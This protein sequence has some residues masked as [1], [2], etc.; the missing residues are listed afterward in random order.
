[1][2]INRQIKILHTI[3][4]LG[5]GGLEGGVVKL[6]NKLDRQRFVPYVTA[7]RGVDQHGQASLASDIKVLCL[8]KREGRDWS[9]VRQMASFFAANQIDIVHSHN[10]ETWLYSFLAARAAGVPIFVHGEHGRDT[11]RMTDGW[12]KKRTKAFL[13][14][15]S[16]QLT[17]VSQDIADLMA[18]NWG[19]NSGKVIVIPNGIDLARFKLPTD[20]AAAKA[21][22][23]FGG[24]FAL[25]GTAIGSLRPVKDVPTLVKAFAQAKRKHTNCHLVIAGIKDHG[26]DGYLDE[27][28]SLIRAN[29]IGAAVHFLGPCP[30]IEHFMQALDLYVNSSVYEGMSNTLLEAMG[31]GAAIVATDVGGTPFIIR[32][33]YNGLLVPAK[34][35]ETMAGAICRI[36][37]STSV[38]TTLVQNGREYVELNHRQE[39]FIA[40]HEQIYQTLYRRK[41]K[42]R[43]LAAGNSVDARPNQMGQ[44]RVESH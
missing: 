24:N 34:S 19:V 44:A 37:E 9:L 29:A 16:D 12:L 18:A 35:P 38:K 14:R 41:Q 7:I 32:D 28:K 26:A 40:K 3:G 2:Q 6:V 39:S 42:K 1:M 15:Q 5:F 4:R 36:L 30:G 23:G 13:A 20:R 17:T 43:D 22:L 25:I 10:W 27:I 33:E 31:C 21:R 8:Q 11:E